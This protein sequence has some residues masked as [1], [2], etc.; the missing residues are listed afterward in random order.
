MLSIRKTATQWETYVSLILRDPMILFYINS[1]IASA[2]MNSTLLVYKSYKSLEL[3]KTFWFLR[4]VAELSAYW[5]KTQVF[6]ACCDKGPLCLEGF[7]MRSMRHEI[8]LVFLGNINI[9]QKSVFLKKR[10]WQTAIRTTSL[11][12]PGSSKEWEFSG[13]KTLVRQQKTCLWLAVVVQDME[14]CM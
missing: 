13:Q 1:L 7:F 11:W 9:C 14:N 4:G 12:G 2:G 8:L 6:T 3:G 5:Y 10:S